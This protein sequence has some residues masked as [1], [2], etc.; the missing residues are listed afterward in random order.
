MT[1]PSYW[2]RIPASRWILRL[3]PRLAA[4]AGVVAAAGCDDRYLWRDAAEVRAPVARAD[5][6]EEPEPVLQPD[7][8]RSDETAKVTGP[9]ESGF[10]ASEH[11]VVEA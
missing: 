4:A 5:F 6:L 8:N 11:E 10:A 1:V 9:E 3:R 7:R 2:S